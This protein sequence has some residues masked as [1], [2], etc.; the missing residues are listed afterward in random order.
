V[1][2]DL[3]QLGTG[4]GEGNGGPGSVPKLAGDLT[5][6]PNEQ[7]GHREHRDSDEKETLKRVVPAISVIGEWVVASHRRTPLA[8]ITASKAATTANL[9]VG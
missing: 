1:L 5:G 6:D 2:A 7:K 3:D 4:L 8:A 9:S